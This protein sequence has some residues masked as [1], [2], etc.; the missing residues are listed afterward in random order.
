MIDIENKILKFG[1]GDI[2]VG[3]DSFN[4][5]VIFTE[6]EPDKEPGYSLTQEDKETLNFKEETR[7]EIIILSRVDDYSFTKYNQFEYFL[8]K[9]MMRDIDCF[10]FEG[11]TFD[12]SNYNEKSVLVCLSDLQR[13][14]ANY[15]FCVAA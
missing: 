6:F 9:V 3:F 2:A 5:S 11:Y 7:T 1:Y 13:S 15:L 14:V 12:F 4:Y 8:K 10:D